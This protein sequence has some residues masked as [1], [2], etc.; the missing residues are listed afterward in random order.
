MKTYGFKHEIDY[1]V[2]AESEDE[3]VIVVADLIKRDWIEYIDEDE[4]PDS[5]F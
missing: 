1:V 3:A 2:E 5:H 4:M